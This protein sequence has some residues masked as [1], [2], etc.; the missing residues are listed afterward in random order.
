[1]DKKEYLGRLAQ[2][3]GGIKGAGDILSEIEGHFAD[4]AAK[5]RSEEEIAEGLGRP[6]TLA[7]EYRA[8][9]RV[10]SPGEAQAGGR[11]PRF[12]RKAVIVAACATVALAGIILGAFAIERRNGSLRKEAAGDAAEG[13]VSINVPGFSLSVGAD[14]SVQMQAGEGSPPGMDGNGFGSFEVLDSLD[15][16]GLRGLDALSSFEGFVRIGDIYAFD[17]GPAAS[18]PPGKSMVDLRKELAL[19]GITRLFVSADIADV[20]VKPGKDGFLRARLVGSLDSGLASAMVLGLESPRGEARLVARLPR[21]SSM[22]GS[23]RLVLLVELPAGLG[24]DLTIASDTGDVVVAGLSPSLLD[25]SSST[26]DV[27]IQELVFGEARLRTDTGD[28]LARNSGGRRLF[29][30]SDTGD[31]LLALGGRGCTWKAVSDTGDIMSPGSMGSGSL[32]GTMGNGALVAELGTDT[33]DILIK[34]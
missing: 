4:G 29:M 14:G 23:D 10:A 34:D 7:R 26:G 19:S 5:G 12:S 8:A 9:S 20:L 6:E 1:M 24:F 31:L 30:E 22:D 25:A 21:R 11:K 3:L 16:S 32:S 2:G 13:M 33:G 28:I 15:G 17:P 18:L 27:G